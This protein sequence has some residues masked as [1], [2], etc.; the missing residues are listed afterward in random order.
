MTTCADAV[1]EG[2]TRPVL[3]D[4]LPERGTSGHEAVLRIKVE[5]GK[6]EVVVTGSLRTEAAEKAIAEL[7]SAG[8][9]LPDQDGGAPIRLGAASFD[10]AKDR[11][12]TLVEIPL[13]LLPPAP[14]RAALVLP[15]LPVSI[16]RASGELMTVCT[17][18]HPIIVEDPIANVAEAKPQPNPAPLP[19]REDFTALRVFLIVLAAV[20]V[21]AAIA[22][23]VATR[24]ARRARL[25]AP[26]PPR[27]PPWE[28]ALAHF[29]ELKASGTLERGQ[30][31]EYV[32]RVSEVLREYLGARYGFEGIESTTAEIRRSL[33][34]LRAD[35]IPIPEIDRLLETTDLV[36]FAN[37][38]P[39]PDDC[40]RMLDVAEAIVRSTMMAP[41]PAPAPPRAAAHTSSPPTPPG[42][43][44]R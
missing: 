9:A 13:V 31:R 32:D 21:V 5:H 12:E 23:Y 14:G 3:K 33:T 11:A 40:V 15:P 16:A 1:P 10:A 6:G 30:R 43:H 7:R 26:P 44:A 42:S 35:S 22:A 19:Q 4:S 27:R 25:K 38:V 41:M 20:V 17:A 24:L 28:A 37:V 29:A 18:P 2:A 34:M 39:P 8:F 36:K